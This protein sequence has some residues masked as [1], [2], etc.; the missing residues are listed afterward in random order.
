MISFYSKDDFHCENEDAISS[1]ITETIHFEGYEEGDIEIVFCDDSYLHELN[2]E[3][4]KH[5]T[6]TDII[7]FDY[8]VGKQIHGE[9]YISIE[10]VLENAALFKTD[11]ENELHRVIIHGILHY[12]GYNDKTVTESDQMR[13]KEEEALERRSFV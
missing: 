4:L 6:L 7:S 9:V 3:F 13:T 5:D 1:W 8:S 10:R 2:V 11:F 12:C